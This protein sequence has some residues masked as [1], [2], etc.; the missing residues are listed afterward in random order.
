MHVAGGNPPMSGTRVIVHRF[1]TNLARHRRAQAVNGQRIPLDCM[2]VH[3]SACALH[4]VRTQ[5]TSSI[6]DGVKHLP[7]R[8]EMMSGWSKAA[9]LASQRWLAG[10]ACWL[11]DAC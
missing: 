4:D 5:R 10:S 7:E 2:Q 6:H 8:A 1:L 3:A 11:G 9:L